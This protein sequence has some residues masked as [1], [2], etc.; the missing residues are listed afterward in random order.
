MTNLGGKALILSALTLMAAVETPGVF[1]QS[2]DSKLIIHEKLKTAPP[3]EPL[4]APQKQGNPGE[5]SLIWTAPGD[6]GNAGT[7]HHYIIRYSTNMIDDQNWGTATV[8][9]NPPAPLPAGSAQTYTIAGLNI[10]SRYYFAL[11]SYDEIGNES[12][13]S[14][15]A[16]KYAGG[17]VGPAP[18]RETI[19]TAQ[20]IAYLYADTVHANLPIIYQFALDTNPLFSAPS[21]KAD[22]LVDSLS[23]VSY[24]NLSRNTSYYWRV[25]AMARDRSDSS[26]WSQPD[27]FF[28]PAIQ[29]NGPTVTVTAPNG[30]ELWTI[31][32][33]SNIT[34]TATDN[35][36]VTAY[37]LEYSTNAGS[38]WQLIRDWTNGNPQS[39]SWTI[40]NSPSTQAR[41]KV[42]A[43]DADNNAAEDIS[44]ANFTIGANNG[45]GL[46][47]RVIRPNGGEVWQPGSIQNI[48]WSDT[49]NVSITSNKLEYSTDAGVSWT[50]IRDWTPGDP[51]Q[52]SVTIP[53][54]SSS[55]CRIKVWIRDSSGLTAS[56]ISDNNFT[57]RD[58]TPPTVRVTAPNGG[59]IWYG[60]S[61]HGLTWT[62]SDNAGITSYRLE[63]S[64]N[65]GYNWLSIR[66]WTAGDPHRIYWK[67]PNIS[68]SSCRVRVSCR[69]AAGNIGSDI[70]DRSF[71]IRYSGAVTSD[72]LQVDTT[73]VD[74]LSGLIP[75]EY[76]MAPAYPNPFNATT[77]IEYGLP[78]ASQV[79][80]SIYDVTGRQVARILDEYQGAGY[81]QVIWN[82]GSVASG[83]YFYRIQAD[84]FVDTKK[85]TLL[86]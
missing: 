38:N 45:Q 16:E 30:G 5:I 82:A 31:G 60:N 81:H 62:D 28:M 11:K 6:D 27:S 47:A 44:N 46:S 67:I 56:D 37:K 66:A 76:S 20:A 4:S 77:T 85:V 14:N 13:L 71:T 59:E 32:Q 33:A 79:T 78:Q 17:I 42:S 58:T 22:S 51:H 34:W 63:Y 10:G 24:A 52:L 8:A 70:S 84:N 23:S 41:V 2:S 15:V 9:P 74:S 43:R 50:V 73:G 49:G 35:L 48:S 1:G 61:I 39:F 7:A 26:S 40:P 83:Q 12:Q 25:R 80:I 72:S 19:D 53:N 65:G 18:R 54:L 3:N 57:I 36:G 21:I 75:D 69:D 86:K 68:S 29:G 55:L 64:T